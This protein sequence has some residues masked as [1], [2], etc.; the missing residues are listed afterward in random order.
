MREVDGLTDAERKFLQAV[1]L[2]TSYADRLRVESGGVTLARST[3]SFSDGFPLPALAALRRKRYFRLLQLFAERFLQSGRADTEIRRHYAQALIE[4][5]NIALAIH[6]LGAVT[7]EEPPGSLEWG[8][9]YGLLGRAYKQLYAGASPGDEKW[10]RTQLENAVTAYATGYG[11]LRS[12]YHGINLVALLMRA[13]RDKFS[14]AGYEGGAAREI[15]QGIYDEILRNKWPQG[16]DLATIA[17]ASLALDHPPDEVLSWLRLY[18]MRRDV[19]AFELAST[20]RQFREVWQIKEAEGGY[21]PALTLLRKHLFECQEGSCAIDPAAVGPSID[22]A[23]ALDKA[24]QEEGIRSYEWFRAGL[25]RS[26]SVAQIKTRRNLGTGFLVKGS[27]LNPKWG[28]DPV[29]LTNSHVTLNDDI[30]EFAVWFG[31]SDKTCPVAER[32]WYLPHAIL[33]AAVFRLKDLPPGAPCCPVSF[34][35]PP[36]DGTERVY[37]IGHPNG[38]GL[39]IS[40]YNNVLLRANPLVLHYYTPT[41]P[42]SS[43]SPVFD[44]QWNAIGLHHGANQGFLPDGT[45]FQANEGIAMDA[46]RCGAIMEQPTME[47]KPFQGSS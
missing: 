32:L 44:E 35:S 43:G 4:T 2:S 1:L 11:K 6:L 30:R 13:S 21:A 36:A 45:P 20:L 42:G 10:R 28:D 46:I 23:R 16:W 18:V 40:L 9:A 15:A 17:E 26:R 5:G 47:P 14:P 3:P 24:A 25:E 7:A 27:D 38:G 8:E 37:V 31:A 12:T 22:T 34:E 41:E 19:D 39:S 29:F 33:D